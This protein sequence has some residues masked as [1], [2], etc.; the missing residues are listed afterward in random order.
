M[1]IDV[2]NHN[3]SGTTY[4]NISVYY[5]PEC[6]ITW[7]KFSLCFFLSNKHTAYMHGILKQRFI[8]VKVM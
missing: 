2:Y 7:T 8:V 6:R 1:F 3:G 4:Q 5:L